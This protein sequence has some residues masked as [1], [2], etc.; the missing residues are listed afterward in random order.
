[1]G[2]KIFTVGA[3]ALR[4]PRMTQEVYDLMKSKCLTSLKPLFKRAVVPIEAPE[5]TSY[6]DVDVLVSLESASLPRVGNESMDNTKLRIWASIEERLK[7][8]RTIRQNAYERHMALPFPVLTS[9]LLERQVALEAS[10]AALAKDKIFEGLAEAKSEA[11]NSV[12]RAVDKTTI[13]GDKLSDRFVQVDVRLC[14][15]DR[16]LKWLSW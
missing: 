9:S 2:G 10:E 14:E 6:G 5:K 8:S 11:T 1:M 15:T 16:E 4:T 3:N 7:A 12:D 13:E